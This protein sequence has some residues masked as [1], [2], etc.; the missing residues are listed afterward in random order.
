MGVGGLVQQAENQVRRNNAAGEHDQ[1]HDA[2]SR[3]RDDISAHNSP[4]G[5][6]S[7]G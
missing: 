3:D 2:V 5:T 1:T 7:I 4:P 6:R